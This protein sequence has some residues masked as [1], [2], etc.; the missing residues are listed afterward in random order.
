MKDL[1]E[2]VRELLEK[3]ILAKDIKKEFNNTNDWGSEMK[4]RVRVVGQN[5]EVVDS[6]WAGGQE[7]LDK[8]KN[9]WTDSGTYAKFFRDEY[10]IKFDVVDTFI[11]IK[12]SG[13]YKKIT[14]NGIVGVVLKITNL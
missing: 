6:F 9:F 13:R 3:K 2:T 11:Q 7:A 10:N 12:A 14:K 1:V 5:L 8:L 4:D